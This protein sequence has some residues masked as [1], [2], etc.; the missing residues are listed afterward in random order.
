M[1]DGSGQKN[2]AVVCLHVSKHVVE[3]PAGSCLKSL[4]GDFARA[5]CPMNLS[6]LNLFGDVFGGFL[7][8]NSTTLSSNRALYDDLMRCLTG[9][10][11]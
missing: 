7:Y 6:S 9:A 11:R 3:I 2:G 10:S 5:T 4:P 8:Q 1:R